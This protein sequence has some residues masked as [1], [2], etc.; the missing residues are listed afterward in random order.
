MRATWFLQVPVID[1]WQLN[2]LYG[3]I[4]F[5]PVFSFYFH[6]SAN[7]GR[8]LF[9]SAGLPRTKLRIRI[10]P[11]V[12][13]AECA[14][15]GSRGFEARRCKTLNINWSNCLNLPASPG[16]SGQPLPNCGL[17]WSAAVPLGRWG[18]LSDRM[19]PSFTIV[20]NCNASQ[21]G[22]FH[23]PVRRTSR[24]CLSIPCNTLHSF[25]IERNRTHQAEG[26]QNASK[27]KM[28]QD[29]SWWIKQM[30]ANICKFYSWV[31]KA[32]C[33]SAKAGEGG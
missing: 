21:T 25:A 16:I 1:S 28:H 20:E 26:M 17:S 2:V 4:K 32:R 33:S 11:L 12:A 22:G 7:G 3:F 18:A 14:I 13:A 30:H 31:T 27:I 23:R 24:N 5:Y 15:S 19:W 29:V 10:H 8:A 6:Q 9:V